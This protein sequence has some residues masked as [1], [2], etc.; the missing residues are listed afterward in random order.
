MTSSREFRYKPGLLAKNTAINAVW[1]FVRISAQLISLIVVARGLGPD[2]YGTF[3]GVSGLAAIGGGLATL[4]SNYLL[5]Q[6]V[7][8]VPDTF[9]RYWHA[10]LLT[11][12]SG[13]IGLLTLFSL[14]APLFLHVN[15]GVWPIMAIGASELVCYPIV[16]LAGFA[17]QAH[18]RLGWGA[19]LPALMAASRAIG[20]IL[21]GAF[22][23][24]G[25]LS[26]YAWFHFGASISALVC[27]LAITTRKLS[28][29]TVWKFFSLR[30]LREGLSFSMPWF[31]TNALGELDKVLAVRL[32]GAEATGLYTAAYRLMS[33][34]TLPV[35]SLALAAQPRLF[36]LAN[37]SGNA[38][39][40]LVS[41]LSIAA[42]LYSVAA[43]IC[44]AVLA[45]TLPI[46][47]GQ[48]F[49][50]SLQT[51]RLL[52][53]VLPLFAFRILGSIVLL[54]AGHPIQRARIEAF[55]ILVL[56]TLATLLIRPGSLNGIVLAVCITEATMDIL[57][58][59]AIFKAFRRTAA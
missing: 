25:G 38:T 37:E 3:A 8:R 7:A 24:N 57:L 23:T 27:V 12:M 9:S 33:I 11:T 19:A 1:Q 56:Y 43:M 41:Q 35:A 28:P 52:I 20:A 49:M 36:R 26:D 29:T 42:I 18:E 31:T 32:A 51:A 47:L 45:I 39:Q 40:R 22:D 59:V 10:S 21:Y 55:G 15:I 58:W 54:S 5:L 34:L 14:L 13:G 17:F 48:S 50:P 46:F 30:E 16:Y 2:G 44:L 6:G 53:I 4:G